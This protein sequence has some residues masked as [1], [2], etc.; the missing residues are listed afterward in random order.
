MQAH[1]ALPT[2]VDE[3]YTYEIPS[4][5]GNIPEPGRRVLVPFGSRTM[6]GYV[7][8]VE[9]AA[10]ERR[11]K[12]ILEVLDETPLFPEEM[13]PF[14]RW[15]AAY[16]LHPIGLVIQTALPAGLSVESHRVVVI[17]DLGTTALRE[18][19]ASREESE[20]LAA[21]AHGRPTRLSLLKN[22]LPG[23]STEA[24][25]RRMAGMEWVRLEN[26]LKTDTVRPLK[27]KTYKAMCLSARATPKQK[28]VLEYLW[29]RG[30]TSRPRILESLPGCDS[31][32]RSLEKR[33]WVR[34]GARKVYRNP[35]GE[36]YSISGSPPLLTPEQAQAARVLAGAIQRKKYEAFML[37]G[38]TGSGKTE[39]YLEAV[40][41]VL[42][43]G[44]SALILCPEISLAAQME[45]AFRSRFGD[46]LA[47][48]HSGLNPGQRYDQWMRVIHG[49]AKVVLGARS[50]I[51]APLED[52]G[53]VIVDEEHEQAYK[54]ED[55]LHYNARDLA[56]VR[57]RMS[58]AVV[59][60]GSATPSFQTY[61]NSVR[62]KHSAIFLTE[63]VGGGVLPEIQVVDMAREKPGT[64]FSS[65]LLKQ[66]AENL[67]KGEQAILFVN[68]RG[69][70]SLLFCIK[71][72]TTVECPHCHVSLTLHAPRSGHGEFLL[73]HYCGFKSSVP[74]TCSVCGSKHLVTMGAGT[75]R[76]EEA[77]SELFPSARI[78][79]VDRDSVPTR[80]KLFRALRD[81]HDGEL[82]ILIGT[83]MIAKGL[84]FPGVTLVGVPGADQ[85]LHFPD[86][87]ATERTFQI[88]S[89]V[90]GRSGRRNKPGKVIIQSYLP[91]HYCI[92]HAK[93]HRF[94]GFY[95]EEITQRA[96]LD[97]PPFC[98]LALV[99]VSSTDPIVV[100]EAA[101]AV[102]DILKHASRG[103][104]GVKVLG[105]A[106]APIGK[107][108]NR[109]R[110]HLLIKAA[111]AGMLHACLDECMVR[112]RQAV[113][114]IK[115]DLVLDVDPS[116][117]L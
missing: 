71:C 41:S 54:Q 87:A 61:H 116:S 6:A 62:G 91:D 114:K 4:E 24:V 109:Y 94:H 10:P 103:S 86:Y 9:H 59:V 79:R 45:G 40:K 33:G 92:R 73:C 50:A 23:A 29:E 117:M 22:K 80:S 111:D 57:A 42:G 28:A 99:R 78:G 85:S 14:F 11:L 13:I 68:R 48:L 34:A 26:H 74:K 5:W 82:D 95:L 12:P 17:T 15:I 52:P 96:E 72:R 110:W 36:E 51:F 30:E 75:E 18:G 60:L 102:G 49:K 84:D 69:Y 89:Q 25:L 1:V 58:N 8:E 53:L 70:A 105:P 90:A 2:A 115:A 27:V 93:E 100:R 83:Q 46:S 113:R 7:L 35:F 56:V 63:R 66:L 112:C 76:M 32:L 31:T 16:Y 38:I 97:Y 67:D 81:F 43:E 65:V 108:R 19:S 77:L 106:P 21:L 55:G 98:R 37:F 64:R 47:V 104:R 39:V 107:I 20:I 3:A 101:G 44:R 88:L